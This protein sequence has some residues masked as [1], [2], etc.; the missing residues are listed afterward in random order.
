[1]FSIA[2]RLRSLLHQ[3]LSFIV[4]LL[5]LLL[6]RLNVADAQV[7]TFDDA[8][9]VAIREAPVLRADTALIEAAEYETVPAGELPDPK[10][11]LGLDNVPVEGDDRYSTGADFM[12]M[13]RI[14][15]MQEFPNP[16]KRKARTDQANAQ[17]EVMR[18]EKRVQRQTVLRETALA[19]IA[20]YTWEQ[21]LALV[22]QL[23]SENTLLDGVVQAQLAAAKG[24]APDVLLPQE[25]A[26]QIAAL[27]DEIVA[28][29]AQSIAQLRR[30]I[31]PAAELS[32]SGEVPE[33]PVN[34]AELRNRLH[35]HPELLSFASQEQ[36]VNADI[37]EARADKN[38]DWDVEFA[39]LERGSGYDDM[40]MLEVRVDLPVFADSRQNPTIASQL[41]KR[42]ALD[43]N[44][45]SSL[46]EHIAMLE[47]E[48]SE[49]QRLQQ[50]EQRFTD[51]LLPLAEKKVA[52]ALASWRNNTG[53]LTN[54]ISA[55]SE[56]ISTQLRAI[57]T[58]GALRQS[59]ARLH[60]TYMDISENESSGL[61]GAQP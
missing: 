13:Q 33:W 27:R 6:T 9:V 26:A 60:Y 45:E 43:A 36:A 19:W 3:P 24:T 59:A 29:Q 54:V 38:P 17:V 18:A 25:E 16:A 55:R 20:R 58:T 11:V 44:R 31:G 35:Q 47:T 2:L 42:V 57:A 40:V 49:H 7:L 12:T 61:T 22:S 34:G 10:L 52:L 4:L 1:M 51:V 30:W 28:G 32:L 48:V 53:T 46:R 8:L 39:W 14:G 56:R 23:Q 5:L 37:A 15:L 50:A 41:A 21:Q